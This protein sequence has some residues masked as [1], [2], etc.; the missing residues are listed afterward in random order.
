MSN[1]SGAKK[2]DA[3]TRHILTKR[4]KDRQF[5]ERLDEFIG[6]INKMAM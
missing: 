3:S 5:H 2:K 6:L 1:G 4:Q